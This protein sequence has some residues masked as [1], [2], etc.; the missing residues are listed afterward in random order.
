[1][2]GEKNKYKHKCKHNELAPSELSRGRANI[3]TA[4]GKA[5]TKGKQGDV[6]VVGDVGDVGGEGAN[7][8]Y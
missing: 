8:K 1:M 3:S 4:L 2:S 5:T 6:G 7:R